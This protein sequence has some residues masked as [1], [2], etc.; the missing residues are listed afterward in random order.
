MKTAIKISFLLLCLISNAFAQRIAKHVAFSLHGINLEAVMDSVT[1]MGM[2]GERLLILYGDKEIAKRIMTHESWE[3]KRHPSDYLNEKLGKPDPEL[4]PKMARLL[5]W[6]DKKTGVKTS[7]TFWDYMDG[8]IYKRED[9]KFIDKN[10]KATKD[11]YGDFKQ[12]VLSKTYLKA[13]DVD[14]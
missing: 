12:I 1:E 7:L 5:V 9:R 6:T 14:K 11:I 8:A 4:E 10:L 2:T 13:W 3:G